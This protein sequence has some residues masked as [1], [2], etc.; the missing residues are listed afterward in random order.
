[1]GGRGGSVG[2]KT[3][4]AAF[5][6]PRVTPKQ[7]STMSRKDLETMAAAIYANNATQ[8][9]LTQAEGIRRARALMDGNSDAQ[10]RKYIQRNTK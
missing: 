5:G 10:L 7:V 1:M 2:G 4:P 9:G 3:E 8:N 6:V